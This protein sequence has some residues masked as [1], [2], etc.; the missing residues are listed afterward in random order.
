[1]Q[2]QFSE[3]FRFHLPR[4]GWNKTNFG[5]A[6]GSRIASEAFFAASSALSR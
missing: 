1:M 4:R 2:Q 6:G 5:T 3:L